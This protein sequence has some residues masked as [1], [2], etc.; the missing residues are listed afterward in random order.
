MKLS[1][2]PYIMQ[3]LTCRTARRI[4][5]HR[6][7]LRPIRLRL[8]TPLVEGFPTMYVKPA[9]PVGPMST[10]LVRTV[11]GGYQPRTARRISR[12]RMR[13][14]PIRLRLST[15]LVEGFP[16]MHVKP[17]A[18]FGPVSV[19]PLWNFFDYDYLKPWPE[20]SESGQS[21]RLTNVFDKQ[22]IWNRLC[23]RPWLGL[24]VRPG[25]ETNSI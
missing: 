24:C 17:V 3:V 18:P 6:M 14:R 5:P 22:K 8:S 15:P 10:L 4:S 9:E 12:H 1:F 23:V 7:R 25:H 13:P 20:W 19:D 11:L 16:T 2:P 21:G